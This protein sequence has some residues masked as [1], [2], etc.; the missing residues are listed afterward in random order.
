MAQEAFLRAFRKLHLWRKDAVFSSWLFSLA[1]NLYRSELR[2]IPVRSVPLEDAPEPSVPARGDG[3]LE[4]EEREH[5][6]RQAVSAL[7]A[8]YRDAVTVY[9]FHGMDISAAA[10]SLGLSEG[11]LKSR[12]FRGR[13]ILR[14]KLP[15]L[16]AE[17]YPEEAR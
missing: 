3:E 2:R 16:I 4:Y 15:R 6:V 1:T 17:P 13:E 7:P 12:L 11:T 14:N 10:H 8:K 5:I 9:Y